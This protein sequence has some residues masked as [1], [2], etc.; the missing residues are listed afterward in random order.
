MFYTCDEPMPSWCDGLNKNHS[1]LNGATQQTLESSRVGGVKFLYEEVASI[2]RVVF[3]NLNGSYYQGMD[4]DDEVIKFVIEV[5][6]DTL[7]VKSSDKDMSTD[8][9]VAE[10]R[11]VVSMLSVQI[12]QGRKLH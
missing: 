2:A 6:R 9:I 12:D 5:S 11:N 7:V 1:R 8:E 10:L 3:K 4:A